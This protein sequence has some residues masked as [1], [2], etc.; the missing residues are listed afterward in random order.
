MTCTEKLSR[1]AGLFMTETRMKEQQ[2]LAEIH[3][4]KV[5][6]VKKQICLQFFPV[7]PF[8]TLTTISRIS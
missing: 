2:V 4:L 5:C 1:E 3:W 7:H 8:V 6:M